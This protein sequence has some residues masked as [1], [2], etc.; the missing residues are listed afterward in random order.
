MANLRC[1]EVTGLAK[2]ATYLPAMELPY[3]LS[4]LQIAHAWNKISIDG[5]WYLCD[6]T[7]AAG[8]VGP[9]KYL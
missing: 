7:W 3:K 2:G 5:V 4:G 8:S 9:G 1:C 6:A